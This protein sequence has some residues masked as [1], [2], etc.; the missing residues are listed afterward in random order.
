[1]KNTSINVLLIEAVGSD[2][3]F[4]ISMT[5]AFPIAARHKDFDLGYLSELETYCDQRQIME[6]RGRV[7]GGSSSK[8]GMVT[9]GENPIDYDQ[10]SRN[11]LKNWAFKYCLPYFRKMETS[12]KGPNDWCGDC[13]PQIIE[14]AKEKH[15]LDQAY[16]VAG[17]QAGYSYTK[18]QNGEILVGFHVA[19]SFTDNGRRCSAARAY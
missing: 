15:K 5:A 6:P 13:G 3:R 1:M 8:N 2:R 18:D 16:L 4:L 17:E 7:L 11:S 10:W 9:N 19:Q 12:E 14:T